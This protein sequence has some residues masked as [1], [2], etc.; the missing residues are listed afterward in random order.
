LILHSATPILS[1]PEEYFHLLKV[2]LHTVFVLSLPIAASAATITGFTGVFDPVNWTV[3][4][5]GDDRVD[6]SGIP[7]SAMTISNFGLTDQLDSVP[8]PGTSLL[9]GCGLVLF[10]GTRVRRTRIRSRH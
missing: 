3:T 2:A 6:T 7:S 9:I 8:E 4:I 10:G 5:G 1:S